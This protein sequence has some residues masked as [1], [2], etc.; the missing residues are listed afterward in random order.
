LLQLAASGRTSIPANRDVEPALYPIAGYRVCGERA[1]R[2]DILE[3]LADLIRPALAW[4]EGATAPKPPGAIV[5]GGFTITNAMTSLTGASGEDFASILRSL[6]YRMDRRPKP[7]EPAPVTEAKETARAASADDATA[8]D[9]ATAEAVEEATGSDDAAAADAATTIAP[10]AALSDAPGVAEPP[11]PASEGTID[12]AE[13]TAAPPASTTVEEISAGA[14]PTAGDEALSDSVVE[15]ATGEPEPTASPEGSTDVAAAPVERASAGAAEPALI[16]VWRPGRTGER[17][18]QR[19]KPRAGAPQAARVADAPTDAMAAERPAAATSAPAAEAQ[20]ATAEPA[21][22]E[23]R[24]GRHRRKG[25]GQGGQDRRFD[26]PR[27]DRERAPPHPA[28][29][30]RREPTP[31]PN[32]PFA[33][34]A[35]LKAQL[36]AEAKERR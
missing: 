19:F 30:E 6:G 21:P 3:R 31:D 4:R 2:V 32:S 28:R 10:D 11:D 5:G 1:V 33:K 14:I 7:P 27:R 9:G 23:G 35:A 22:A 17:R 13:T 12:Q 29:H 25:G 16:E 8:D 18:R 26:R 34:L 15:Q 24:Q 20:T 36:E